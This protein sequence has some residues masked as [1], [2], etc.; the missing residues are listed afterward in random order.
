MTA[1]ATEPKLKGI[2]PIEVWEQ[3]REFLACTTKQQKFLKAY[4]E[5]GDAMAASRAAYAATT[6]KG[7]RDLGYQ[8]LRAPNVQTALRLYRGVSDQ[9]A[10]LDDLAKRLA[11]HEKITIAE[12]EALKILVNSPVWT[13][14]LQQP[15]NFAEAKAESEPKRQRQAAL[16]NVIADGHEKL[17]SVLPRRRK[18]TPIIVTDDVSPNSPYQ[19]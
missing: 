4:V 7:F 3:T 18:R 16:R 1:V 17:D 10:I 2:M 12:I 13:A 8:T 15:G 6:E 9:Q 14:H 5:A 11:N 19:W